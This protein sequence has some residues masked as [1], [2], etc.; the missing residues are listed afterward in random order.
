MQKIIIYCPLLIFFSISCLIIVEYADAQ[1]P[2][3][4]SIDISGIYISDNQAIYNVKQINNTVWILGTTAPN[5]AS[6][7]ISNIFSGT[8]DDK[9]NRIG[10]KWID[11]PLSNNIKSGNVNFDLLIDNSKK[12][13]TLNKI[14]PTIESGSVYPVNTLTKY[15]PAIHSPLTIYLSMEN[16]LINI[17]RSPTLDILYVGISGQKNNE[18]PMTATKYL[19]PRVDGSNITA[20]LRIGPFSIN[21]ENDSLKV[22]ILGL[23]KEDGTPAFT[24]ISLR[25]T[26]IQLMESSYNV[27]DLV[28][29]TNI[30]SSLSPTLIPKGCNGLV[31]IDDLELSSEFL[32]NL[33]VLNGEHNQEKSY[34]GTTSPPGCGPPSQYI[35]ELSIKTHR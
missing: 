20:D 4:N 22:Y 33:T 12:N 21:N 15:D 14:P 24:L 35:V 13:M 23:D 17:P 3:K 8:L 2:S 1:S 32:R 25:N 16:I 11:F 10:G 5:N 34:T 29:A 7:T 30:V 6:G 31:F 26:L 19:G 18:T 9:F 27:T 28:H